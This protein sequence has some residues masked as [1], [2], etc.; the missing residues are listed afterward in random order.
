VLVV[1]W[2]VPGIAVHW[3]I[4]S[5]ASQ[6]VFDVVALM[7]VLYAANGLLTVVRPMASHYDET[8]V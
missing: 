5:V 3:Q 2:A 4:Y 6:E 8:Q 1:T 7:W